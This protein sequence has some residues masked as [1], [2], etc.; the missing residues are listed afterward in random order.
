M[1]RNFVSTLLTGGVVLLVI[2]WLAGDPRPPGSAPVSSVLADET[3]V[4]DAADNARTAA[5]ERRESP[6]ESPA[7]SAAPSAPKLESAAQL[8]QQNPP[9][10]V[11]V[12]VLYDGVAHRGARVRLWH[13]ADFVLGVLDPTVEERPETVT[14]VNGLAEFD[15]LDGDRHLIVE[16]RVEPDAIA[17][18]RTSLAA[19]QPTW[20]IVVALGSGG[21]EGKV[22]GDGGGAH[23]NVRVQLE[24]RPQIGGHGWVRRVLTGADGSYRIGGVPYGIANVFADVDSAAIARRVDV[25][26]ADGEW[27]HV[28]FGSQQRTWR[29]TGRVKLASGGAVRGLKSFEVRERL[30]GEQ[31]Q[32]ECADGGEFAAELA[33]GEYSASVW[34]TR[35]TTQLGDVSLTDRELAQDLVLPGIQLGGRI[36]YTGKWNDAKQP[37]AN[38]QV[39]IARAGGEKKEL[40]S[41]I[42]EDRYSLRSLEAGDYVLTTWPNPM[43]GTGERGVAIKLDG[44]LDDVT[45]DLT[46]TDP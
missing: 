45:V 15:G 35:G 21:V 17:T 33:P 24:T 40:A 1:A 11:E 42:G 39:W 26:L 30:R 22:F 27:K 38:V 43:L 4:D 3:L 46:I 16:A 37:A 12:L 7:V 34:T 32:V 28:D 8:S 25:A 31:I 36:D 44:S 9:G 18:V 13:D 5:P 20:R 19:E 23:A 14:D 2:L 6:A 10:V 29:W 41:H